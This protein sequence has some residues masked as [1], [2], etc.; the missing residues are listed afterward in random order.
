MRP[1]TLDWPLPGWLWGQVTPALPLAPLSAQ[2]SA[3][4]CTRTY[5]CTSLAPFAPFPSSIPIRCLVQSALSSLHLL[6]TWSLRAPS[7]RPV[8]SLPLATGFP[9]LFA[10]SPGVWGGLV[11]ALGS[12]PC[13]PGSTHALPSPWPPW[14]GSPPALAQRC[15]RAGLTLSRRLGSCA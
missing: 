6:S 5:R 8:R 12:H 14:L 1:H 7:S 15:T 10:P 11:G 3:L 9:T 4:V 13:A 2:T